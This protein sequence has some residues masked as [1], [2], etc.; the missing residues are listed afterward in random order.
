MDIQSLEGLGIVGGLCL[1]V[2]LVLRYASFDMVL[3]IRKK[4]KRGKDDP[5]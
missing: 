5:D 2:W 1:V 4:L 3:R